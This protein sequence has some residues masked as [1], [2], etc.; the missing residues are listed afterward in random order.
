[1]LTIVH[2]R[3]MD[4]ELELALEADGTIRGMRCR[5]LSDQG[6]YF[7]TLGV[8]NPSLAVTSVPGPYRIANFEGEVVGVLTNKSPSSPYRGAGGPEA[9]YA[10]ERLFDIAARELGMDPAGVPHEEFDSGR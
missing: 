8:V 1:M 2:A 5:L 3:E 4:I 6:A 7:R 10:R 9:A